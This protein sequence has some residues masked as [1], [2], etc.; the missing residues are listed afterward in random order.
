MIFKV[1]SNTNPVLIATFRKTKQNKNIEHSCDGKNCDR[2]LEYHR[3]VF[4]WVNTVF[5]SNRNR[6]L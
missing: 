4:F 6:N 2:W 5:T 1:I 3:R